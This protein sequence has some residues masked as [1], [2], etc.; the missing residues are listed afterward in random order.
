MCGSAFISGAVIVNFFFFFFF[1]YAY[2]YVGE[3]HSIG[4]VGKAGRGVCELLDVDPAEVAIMMG[5]FTISFGSCGVNISDI[6][7]GF[8]HL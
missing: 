1:K 7:N 4:A 8:L 5:T 3:A 2:T 6:L